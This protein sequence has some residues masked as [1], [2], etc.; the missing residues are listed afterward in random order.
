MSLHASLQWACF[1]NLLG[2]STCFIITMSK[3][4]ERKNVVRKQNGFFLKRNNHKRRNKKF[5]DRL[6]Q[7][8][9][10]RGDQMRA[11]DDRINR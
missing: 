8:G 1:V 6:G 10:V 5:E 11:A 2:V 7:R 9:W 3:K 4:K